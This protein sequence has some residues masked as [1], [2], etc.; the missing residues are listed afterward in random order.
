MIRY[1]QLKDVE[2]INELGELLHNNFVKLF[3][4][5]EMLKDKLAKILVF[6]EDNKVVGF[7]IAT[8]LYETVDIL[9]IIVDPL[10]RRKKVATNLLD[11]LFS[12]IDDEV[13]TITLEVSVNNVNA[14]NLY[15][16][17]GFEIINTRKKY[18]NGIDGYLM[19]RRMK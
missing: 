19:G 11:Y 14:I 7:I 18:Y 3:K 12:E 10:Y 13:E 9:S 17:F 4:V 8:C 6:V 16:K 2:R 1:A 5:D 15:K